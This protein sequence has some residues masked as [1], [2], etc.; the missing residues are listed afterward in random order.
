MNNGYYV[1]FAIPVAPLDYQPLDTFTAIVANCCIRYRLEH[2]IVYGLLV[3]P[4][5]L[6][7]YSRLVQMCSFSSI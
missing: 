2:V 6:R 4:V 7:V 3:V 5:V 1:G